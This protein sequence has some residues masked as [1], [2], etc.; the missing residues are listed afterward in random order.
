MILLAEQETDQPQK[1]TLKLSINLDVRPPHNLCSYPGKDQPNMLPAIVEKRSKLSF[2]K[3]L[4]R[5]LGHFRHKSK[6]LD[7]HHY[8]PCIVRY[9]KIC[10]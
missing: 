10:A 3:C 6:Y 1:G 9:C 5:P 4:I 2:N 7:E 8:L